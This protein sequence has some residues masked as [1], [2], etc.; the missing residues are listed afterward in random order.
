MTYRNPCNY[1]CVIFFACVY[2][3]KKIFQIMLPKGVVALLTRFNRAMMIMEK[4]AKK[5]QG[6]VALLLFW[7]TE[8][9]DAAFLILASTL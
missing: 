4:Q 5:E 8:N 3:Y 1:N 9:Y 2:I 7:S 6:F